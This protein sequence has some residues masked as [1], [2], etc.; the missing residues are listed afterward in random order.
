MKKIVCILTFAS[1]F[2]FCVNSVNA[3]ILI[4]VRN[5]NAVTATT[6]KTE[7]ILSC[8]ILAEQNGTNITLES[9]NVYI[10]QSGTA[11]VHNIKIDPP[12]NRWQKIT[13]GVEIGI[14]HN[15]TFEIVITHNEEFGFRELPLLFPDPNGTSNM[16]DLNQEFVGY[17]IEL[18]DSNN[19][20]NIPPFNPPINFT[21]I[22]PHSGGYK[23]KMFT[24][25]VRPYYDYI[26]TLFK[27]TPFLDSISFTNPNFTLDNWYG[28]NWDIG[29]PPN[30]M[31]MAGESYRV[32]VHYKEPADKPFVREWM[33]FHFS[34]DIKYKMEL[35][36]NPYC[37]EYRKL[38]NLINPTGG[39]KFAPCDEVLIEWSGHNPEFNV[40]IQYSTNNKKTWAAIAS[41]AGTNTS[42]LWKVPNIISDSCYI[43]ISQNFTLTGNKL[44]RYDSAQILSA[45]FNTTSTKALTTS[46]KGNVV[47]WNLYPVDTLTILSFEDNDGLNSAIYL[48]NDRF[49]VLDS[50]YK[51]L[52]Y[53]NSG[54]NSVDKE[55]SLNNIPA[56]SLGYLIKDTKNRFIVIAPNKHYGKQ[57]TFIDTAGNNIIRTITENIPI[58]NVVMSDN[59]DKLYYNLLD[60]TIKEVD[61][62]DFA[63]TIE[64]D[65]AK[66]FNIIGEMSVSKDGNQIAVG[67]RNVI[68]TRGRRYFAD[69]MIY[70]KP[71]GKVFQNVQKSAFQSVGI[72]FSPSG[73]L[74]FIASPSNPQI[75]VKDLTRMDNDTNIRRLFDTLL[76]MSVS[77]SG[78]GMLAYSKGDTNCLYVSFAMP[79]QTMNEEPFSIVRPSVVLAD[80]SLSDMLI[81]TTDTVIFQMKLCNNGVVRAVF[82]S[83]F[84]PNNLHFRIDDSRVTF[85]LIIEAGECV[86]LSIILI[87]LDTGLLYNAMRLV[88]CGS[89]FDFPFSYRSIDRKLTTNPDILTNDTI[90]FGE[91]CVSERKTLPMLL[92]RNDDTVDVIINEISFNNANF[93]VVYFVPNTILRPGESYYAEISYSPQT[94]GIHTGLLEI[95]YCG[96]N[97][98]KKYIAC[99]GRGIGIFFDLSHQFLPFIPEIPERKII[100]KNTGDA[101]LFIDSIDINPSGYYTCL[102]PLPINIDIG[103]SIELTIRCNDI[104]SIVF[105]DLDVLAKPCARSNTVKLVPYS[106][107]ATLTIGNPTSTIPLV[108]TDPRD[109]VCTIP[110][111]LEQTETYS[112]A[113]ERF[114]DFEFTMNPTLF[115]PLYALS[116]YGLVEMTSN[117][118][119]GDKRVIGLRFTGNITGRNIEILRLYGVPALG[120]TDT[121]MMS[122]NTNSIF[123]GKNVKTTTK[124]GLFRLINVCDDRFLDL[125]GLGYIEFNG[126]YPNPATNFIEVDYEVFKSPNDGAFLEVYDIA[127]SLIS[128]HIIYTNLGQHKYK[129]DLSNYVARTYYLQIIYSNKMT[130]IHKIIVQ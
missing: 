44:L 90:D 35:E 87:P 6:P 113:G 92:F 15:I 95:K 49:V 121:T 28:V 30:I 91:V 47:E 23:Q 48:N 4:S 10:I 51:K 107:T 55:M 102:T 84:F 3:E 122:F 77:K 2:S 70:D 46:D 67:I 98:V 16:L 79:E 19:I 96:Q 110:L 101:V 13:W 31:L 64:Y 111:M 80:S 29:R 126:V 32:Y 21:N 69:N 20:S 74:L 56:S 125:V 109:A 124:N 40:I 104:D 58:V 68:T 123:F 9:N 119:I 7:P 130:T 112:Y 83:G 65:F 33:T 82:E 34:G 62:N 120:N 108:E 94:A 73:N 27:T 129:L 89:N 54:E 41:V 114:L 45:E 115:L 93:K 85:P 25:G 78:N 5:F 72:D 17:D 1:V 103:E 18:Y 38:I 86:D 97:N 60:N 61:L 127:G 100:I 57:I 14:P 8:E 42:Y 11:F 116:D 128:Q 22:I 37:L 76:G 39:E 99:K 105:A 117:A 26:K 50:R 53:A 59:E 106:G 63:N 71:T 66:P 81:G 52:Y 43:R 118:I 88:A 75:S 12:N 36:C 24:F